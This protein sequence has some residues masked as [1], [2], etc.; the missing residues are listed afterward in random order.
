M[1]TRSRHS[2][3]HK[4]LGDL[5]R[6]WLQANR[7]LSPSVEFLPQLLILP[8]VLFIV[9]LLDSIVSSSLPLSG[10]FAPIFIAGLLSTIFAVSVATYTVWTVFHGWFYPDVSPF[11]STISQL[12]TLHGPSI[13]HHAKHVFRSAHHYCRSLKTRLIGIRASS[14]AQ[15]VAAHTPPL[16]VCLSP[17]FSNIR[18]LSL[19][20]FRAKSSD[21]RR[22]NVSSNTAPPDA[23]LEL[24][25]IEAFHATLQMT[26]DADVIDQAVAAYPS[27]MS[28][29]ASRF[30]EKITRTNWSLLLT[31]RVIPPTTYEIESLAY[32]LSDEANI[33]T[34]ITAAV[35]IADP[36]LSGTLPSECIHHRRFYT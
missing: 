24:H 9:G 11:Q 33:R 30:K 8:I 17:G 15:E 7:L 3:A 22:S 19:E 21:I 32:M 36:F 27:L 34:N 20:D 1:L 4:K 2:Q 13:T 25:D 5:H 18:T 12:W 26:H 23:T 10:P 35:F 14:S 31:Y 28:E 6:R 29:C 16:D